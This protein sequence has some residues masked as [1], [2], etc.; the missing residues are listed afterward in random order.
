MMT[1]D[2]SS[3]VPVRGGNHGV[4]TP[5]PWNVGHGKRESTVP[6]HTET[7]STDAG[8]F[9]PI[10]KDGHCV[11]AFHYSTGFNQS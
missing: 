6:Y 7:R 11:D 5:L 4:R 9:Y 8:V 10:S 2:T 1:D 3:Q